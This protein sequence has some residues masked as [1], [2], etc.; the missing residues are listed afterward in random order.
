[1]CVA[2]FRC[3]FSPRGI[4]RD[5]CTLRD[6]QSRE[7]IAATTQH[8]FVSPRP[9]FGNEVS[10]CVH[11]VNSSGDFRNLKP[12]SGA[13]EQRS[14]DSSP[15]RRSGPD[16]FVQQLFFPPLSRSAQQKRCSSLLPA[17]LL[18][19]VLGSAGF[20]LSLLFPLLTSTR[21]PRSRSRTSWAPPCL[22]A[23]SLEPVSFPG[24][25]SAVAK[26]WASCFFFPLF[27][28]IM[29][30][31]LTVYLRETSFFANDA[32]LAFAG[33]QAA[34]LVARSRR[35][36]RKVNVCA[37]SRLWPAIARRGL[38]S[39]FDGRSATSGLCGRRLCSRWRPLESR[40][41]RWRLA[42]DA[43]GRPAAAL[44]ALA[45]SAVRSAGPAAAADA[46]ATAA[47]PDESS[48]LFSLGSHDAA[49]V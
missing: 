2:L 16:S 44:V 12:G 39:A 21:R 9:G 28:I 34:R 11:R 5:V 10:H 19:C 31:T 14:L 43:N 7:P 47:R 49:A 36:A 38:V 17:P 24:L 48:L 37:R 6:T 18:R 30:L 41:W 20:S 23:S 32:R 46:P 4:S 8:C 3:F 13:C 45:A 26:A 42:A 35:V 1:M 15:Q 29:S 27:F 40:S 33:S 25:F 22:P